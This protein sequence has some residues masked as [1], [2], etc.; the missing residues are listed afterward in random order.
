VIQLKYNTDGVRRHIIIGNTN[1]KDE[2]LNALQDK[3]VSKVPVESPDLVSPK[4]FDSIIKQRMTK[5]AE[6][7]NG[8]KALIEARDEFY[9]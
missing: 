3:P 6:N 2:L 5:L 9:A 8:V 1:L 7:V 4:M